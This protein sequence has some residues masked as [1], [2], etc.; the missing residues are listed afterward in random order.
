M[1]NF[2]IVLLGSV[3]FSCSSILPSD[4]K[5]GVYMGPIY[6]DVDRPN[7]PDNSYSYGTI[8]VLDIYNDAMGNYIVWDGQSEYFDEAGDL[9]IILNDSSFNQIVS[10]ELTGKKVQYDS[11]YERTDGS[12]IQRITGILEKQ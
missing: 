10:F 8:R 11:E 12:Y 5:S 4:D 1:K 3:L 2:I 7:D 9:L 6:V